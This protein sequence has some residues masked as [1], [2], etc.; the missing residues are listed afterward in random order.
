MRLAMLKAPLPRRWLAHQ[1]GSTID[2]SP[3]SHGE[4]VFSDG[5]SGSSWRDGGVQTRRMPDGYYDPSRW[6]FWWLPSHIEMA[7][8]GWYVD[9]E[10]EPY[11][12]I[13]VLRFG[14][15]L[16]S[17]DP[18]GWFCLES[19]AASTL[20]MGDQSWR[21]GPGLIVATM[22]RFLG[23]YK[24]SSPW[25]PKH[26]ADLMPYATPVHPAVRAAARGEPYQFSILGASA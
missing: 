16:A 11:D 25:T 19:I 20:K 26:E 17:Q 23:A 3:Y 2:H 18:I 5:V 8:R 14:F 21:F 4:L 9:H 6:D 7:T 1:I 12:E 22:E 13:G 10:G 24:V 15:C